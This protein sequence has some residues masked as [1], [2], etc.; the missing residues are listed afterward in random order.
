MSEPRIHV[1]YENPAWVT[2]LAE[3]LTGLGAPFELMDVSG[4]MVDLSRL[5]PAGI[6]YSRMSASAHTRGHRYAAEFTACLLHWLESHDR[7]VVN[8]MPALRLELSKVAQYTALEAHGIRTPKTVVATGPGQ[9]LAAAANFDGAFMTKH[10]RGGKGLG[11]YRHE[12][13]STLEA[14]LDDEQYEE[15]VDGITLVQEYVASPDGH[16]TRCEFVGGRFLYALRVNTTEGFELCPADACETD[17]I[18][19]PPDSSPRFQVHSGFASPMISRY[20]RFLRDSGIAIAG[21]EF[22]ADAQG[23]TFTYDINTNTNYNRAAE[24]VAGLDGATAI[25]RY[26]IDELER[27]ENQAASAMA[28]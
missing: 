18:I 8:G 13:L 24:A 3:A 17:G 22:I 25:A 20:E 7:L 26:L 9:V 16:I 12:S 6:Y 10:N 19:C 11:V 28:S 4:G 14:F 21:I 27:S 23:R 5:P 1:L 15:P 2:T